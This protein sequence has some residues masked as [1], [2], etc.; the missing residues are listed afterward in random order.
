MSM[1]AL[2][3]YPSVLLFDEAGLPRVRTAGDPPRA[4][5][6]AQDFSE[7]EDDPRRKSPVVQ[8][9]KD[10]CD[11]NLIL[12]RYKKTGQLPPMM[13][14]AR[15]AD[16]T[17][18]PGSFHEAMNTVTEARSMFADLPAPVRDRFNND[19]GAFFDFVADPENEEEMRSLG[20]LEATDRVVGKEAAEGPDGA[21]APPAP[22]EDPAKGEP[23]E[24]SE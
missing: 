11:I 1:K 8:A 13:D 14:N 23:A 2:D 12:A 15:Y 21:K 20:L 19:P 17:E 7:S 4:H 16:L 10:D 9:S 5:L 18:R 24:G 6:F 22:P 3:V